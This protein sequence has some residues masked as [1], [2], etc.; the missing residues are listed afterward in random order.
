MRHNRKMDMQVTMFVIGRDF[1]GE[2]IPYR[3]AEIHD[4]RIVEIS[5]IQTPKYI[6][7][8]ISYMRKGICRN[9]TNPL[10]EYFQQRYDM[11]LEKMLNLADDDTEKSSHDH[12]YRSNIELLTQ[13]SDFYSA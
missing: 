6:G 5:N 2:I 9:T 3:T 11:N 4:M 1:N 12:S 10:A 7:K 13:F 8:L